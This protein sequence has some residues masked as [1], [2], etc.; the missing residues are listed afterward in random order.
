MPKL[1]ELSLSTLLIAA[2][3]L[4]TFGTAEVLM[5]A[6]IYA[7]WFPSFGLRQ[8]WRYADGNFDDDFWKLTYLF[9]TA[10]RGEPVGNVD[11]DLGWNSP[12][13]PEDPLGIYATEP[14]VIADFVDPILFYGDS[15]VGGKDNIPSKLDFLLPHRSVLNF[16]VGGYG[17]DQ[18]YL[19][20]RAT[21]RDFDNPVVLIGVL[22]YD[23]DRSILGI[24]T[25]QKP[26]FEILD[27]E[28]VLRN[29]PVLSTTQE[30]ID[31][32]PVE[33]KSYFLRFVLFRMRNLIPPSRF[34]KLLGYTEIDD[35]K[36]SVNLAIF[37]DLRNISTELG[38]RTYVVIFYSGEE[39][40]QSTWRE[41]FIRSSLTEMDIEFF[42]TRPYLRNYISETGI[43]LE[44]LYEDDY[45][46][47]NQDG[48]RVVAEGLAEW[49]NE[50]DREN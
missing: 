33:I 13:T 11:R 43:A 35:R 34:N 18:T 1:R 46:H 12:S 41:E 26:Y 49:I 5:R 29:T 39:I 10:T 47:L 28:L 32:N 25:H 15:Y 24:R 8:A 44:E 30:Y 22:T 40:N 20:F 17:V 36:R 23:L 38:I 50:L 2:S 42:D 21:V 19:K 14:Y 9:N 37:R 45:G 6:A 31:E 16:G 3:L 48:R 4:V 7:D 27:D